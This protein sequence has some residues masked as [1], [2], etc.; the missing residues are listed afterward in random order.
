MKRIAKQFLTDT[1]FMVTGSLLC[2]IAIN[3]FLR[4][5]E[6]LTGGMAGTSLI[7]YYKWQGIPFGMLY[8][9]VNIPVFALGYFI[10]GRKFILYSF[11]AVL[12]HSTMFSTVLPVICIPDK[13][14]SALVAGALS[15]AGVALILRTNGMCGGTEII[16]VILNKFYSVNLSVT[17]M[18]V[19]AFVLFGA[20]FLF[21]LDNILY[22]SVFIIMHSQV[23]NSISKGLARRKAVMV[24]SKQ[25]KEILDELNYGKKR[26]GTT[27]LSARGGY[28]GSE[29]PIIY[30]IV[31]SHQVSTIRSVTT[32]IDPIAF[33]VIMEATDI[34]NETVGNQPPWKK[35]LY[36]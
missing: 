33:I 6:F 7:I 30:S 28:T 1:L 19:N 25:W 32:R 26:I 21:P 2:A 24:L 34:I 35:Q 13:L 9:L 11:W 4:P 18:L 3:G 17:N 15:G 31:K 12:I 23:M 27:L 20:S 10:V 29:E 8:F 5:H 16:S 36:R 22:S 14:L